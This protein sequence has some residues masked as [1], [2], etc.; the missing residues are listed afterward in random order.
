MADDHIDALALTWMR[1]TDMYSPV[2]CPI[3]LSRSQR[4]DLTTIAEEM[5]GRAEALL[6]YACKDWLRL[7]RIIGEEQWPKDPR[8]S[9]IRS[10]LERIGRA[11]GMNHA[12]ADADTAHAA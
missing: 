7:R 12:F 10:E 5:G 9:I 8:L 6:S 1:L 4:Q 11:A 3:A 2:G